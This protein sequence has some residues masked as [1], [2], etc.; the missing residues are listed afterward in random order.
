MG[1]LQIKLM[2]SQQ[3]SRTGRACLAF[4]VKS[5]RAV[6]GKISVSFANGGG[7]VPFG[8][9]QLGWATVVGLGRVVGSGRIKLG[10]VSQPRTLHYFRMT[11]RIVIP[12]II[13]SFFKYKTQ[14]LNTPLAHIHTCAY[15]TH[16]KKL[17]KAPKAS[18]SADT[19]FSTKT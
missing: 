18:R 1:R 12:L 9:F 3:N 14:T 2:V 16:A 8:F 19:R 5:A 6:C 4:A 13:F 17:S 15:P 10:F 11:Q 7:V